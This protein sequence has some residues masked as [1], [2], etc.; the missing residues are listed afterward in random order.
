MTLIH[1]V[2]ATISAAFSM[3]IR[4]VGVLDADLT[5]SQQRI[6]ST[7][8]LPLRQTGLGYSR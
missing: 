4:L 5:P 2:Q 7:E 6:F 1:F 8:R 3:G